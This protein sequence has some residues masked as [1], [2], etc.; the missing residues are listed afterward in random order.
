MLPC[1]RECRLVR[2]FDHASRC[3]GVGHRNPRERTRLALGAMEPSP[4]KASEGNSS[5]DTSGFCPGLV[6]AGF[7]EADPEPFCGA[8]VF[9]ADRVLPDRPHA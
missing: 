5:P 1:A 6:E 4:A 3:P 2:G 9:C 7:H 8:R